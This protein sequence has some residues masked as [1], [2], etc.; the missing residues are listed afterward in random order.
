MT[1]PDRLPIARMENYHTHYLG[2]T[3]DKRLFW[4]YETFLFTKP[5]ASIGQDDNWMQ[6]RRDY[7]VLH[8]F[9]GDGNYLTTKYWSGLTLDTSEKEL[10]DKLEEMIAGLGKVHF[11][12][13]E[14][15]IFQTLVDNTIF[16]LVVDEKNEMIHLQPSSLISFQEPWDGEYY[17]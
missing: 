7:V 17:T 8:T 12:D 10:E 15:K 6:Y 9:D 2:K 13:I 3:E 5:R 1:I 16:G 11:Q 4:G 14:I